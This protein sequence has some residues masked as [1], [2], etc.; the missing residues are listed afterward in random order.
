MCKNKDAL[1]FWSFLNHVATTIKSEFTTKVGRVNLISDMVLAAVVVAIFAA[2]T[3]EQITSIVVSI[4]NPN[5]ME[6]LSSADALIA[7]ILLVVFSALC[8]VFLFFYDKLVNDS[9]DR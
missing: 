8:L 4:W 5:I 2:N 9:K 7:F 3:F 6:H 1:G